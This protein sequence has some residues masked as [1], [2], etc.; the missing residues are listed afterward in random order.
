MLLLLG[1]HSQDTQNNISYPEAVKP[2]LPNK[3]A[4]LV[5]AI[6]HCR[7]LGHGLVT[8]WG[9]FL[10]LVRAAQSNFFFPLLMLKRDGKAAETP[11]HFYP[12]K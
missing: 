12:K 8:H 9:H 11:N 1:Y 3:L 6:L 5:S 2:I 7:A 10:R 4:S